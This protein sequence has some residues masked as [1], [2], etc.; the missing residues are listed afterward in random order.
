VIKATGHADT[1]GTDR[2][3][4]GLSK[5]RA[6]AVQAELMRL[7]LSADEIFINWKGEREPLVE[8]NDGVREPQN[9]RVEIIL[10]K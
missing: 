3:N 6:A 7:G 9:R 8:T 1:S 10:Q 4:V 5:R 2:Y